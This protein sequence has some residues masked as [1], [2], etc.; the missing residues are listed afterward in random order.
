MDIFAAI[1]V[2][3]A[4]PLTPMANSK[5]IFERKIGEGRFRFDRVDIRA[6]RRM[7]QK[8]SGHLKHFVTVILAGLQA[9]GMGVFDKDGNISLTDE[10]MGAA[11]ELLKSAAP[12]ILDGVADDALNDFIDDLVGQASFAMDGEYKSLCDEDVAE[13]AFGDDLTM[14]YPVALSVL[15]VNTK[16]GF[17]MKLFR[18][19]VSE[20]SETET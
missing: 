16:D 6:R 7:A 13:A 15:E 8:A 14:F 5:R 1:D 20:K 18:G 2:W 12:D 3:D 17:F 10:N 11:V 4:S 9:D 19:F